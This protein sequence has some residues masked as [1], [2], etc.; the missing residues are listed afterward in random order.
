MQATRKKARRQSGHLA[1]YRDRCGTAWE[2]ENTA[3]QHVGWSVVG[4]QSTLTWL[5]QKCST[6]L[7]SH[8]DI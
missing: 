5:R 3:N 1:S 8:S 6:I 2:Y 7:N 4:R